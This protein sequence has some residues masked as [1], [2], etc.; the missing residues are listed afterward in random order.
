MGIR[1][2][3]V[4]DFAGVLGRVQ[5]PLR[6]SELSTCVAPWTRPPRSRLGALTGATRL[7]S[8]AGTHASCIG[9]SLDNLARETKGGT[10]PDATEDGPP[11]CANTR[12]TLTTRLSEPTGVA[13]ADLATA[14]HS[15]R[16]LL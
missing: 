4:D 11:A 9:G 12:T 13:V 5:G 6:R 10:K 7:S 8:R 1:V 14:R 15:K 2:A 16:R 3:P